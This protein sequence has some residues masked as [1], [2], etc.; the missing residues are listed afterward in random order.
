M[1]LLDGV[2]LAST[3]DKWVWNLEKNG[4]FSTK[5]LANWFGIEGAAPKPSFFDNIWTDFYPKKVFV[6]E[7]SHNTINTN[8]KIQRRLPHV[9]LSPE[10]CHLCHADYET[11]VIFSSIAHLLRTF[12]RRSRS[13]WDGLLLILMISWAFSCTLTGNPF[14]S[15]KKIMWSH[16]IRA[17]LWLIWKERNNRL[18]NKKW[19]SVTLFFF[20]QYHLWLGA[21]LHLF[22]IHMIL[23]L[24]WPIG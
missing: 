14:S 12:G 16:L 17:F 8:D 11:Q 20:Y 13:P 18:F 6:W 21:N 24:S 7:I 4:L 23:H 2:R 10:C 5:C 19:S 1:N 3:R 15:H 9:A 22:S